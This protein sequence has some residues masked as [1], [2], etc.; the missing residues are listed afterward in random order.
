MKIPSKLERL[1]TNA[2]SQSMPVHTMLRLVKTVDPDYDLYERTGFPPNIPIPSINA[3]SQITKDI[4]QEGLLINFVENLIEVNEKGLMGKKLNIRF[5]STI[6]KEIENLG[7]LYHPQEGTFIEKGDSKKTNNWGILLEGKYYELAFL[8]IDI[9]KNT[10]LARKYGDNLV[11]DIISHLREIFTRHVEKRNG[12]VWKWEGDGGLAAFYFDDKNVK[13]VLSGI[14]IILDLFFFNLF[15]SPLKKENLKIRLAA[16]TGSCPY[17]SDLSMLTTDTL[18][19]LKYLLN[20]L[21]APDTFSISPSVYSDLG[22]KL[23]L[24]FKPVTLKN[25][26]YI[27]SYQLEWED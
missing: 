9:V 1:V 10:E 12:R 20:D 25:G 14:D 15:Y 8:A 13:A 18:A 16:H 11:A 7:Y 23:E 26:K 5:L 22:S 27:Y 4:I 24:F 21:T 19:S 6:I 17:L 2:L 3:A